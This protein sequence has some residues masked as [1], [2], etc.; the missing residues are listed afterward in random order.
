MPC[1]LRSRQ[2]SDYQQMLGAVLVHPDQREV[3][4]LFPEII[5]NTDGQTKNDCE[6]NAIRRW[7]KKFRQDHPK[8]PVIITEDAL[9]PNAPHIRDLREHNCRFILGVK[10]GDHAFL[11][12]YVDAAHQQGLVTEHTVVDP[13]DPKITHRFRFLDQVPLNQSNLDV[14]VTFV[15]YWQEGPKGTK[16]FAWVTDLK[17][18]TKNVYKIMRGGRARHRTY[19]HR[20]DPPSG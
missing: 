10:S 3:I 2:C 20:K 15:E 14:L 5:R 4:P 12:D 6:R 16:H 7:L 18:T 9:S 8:L 11:F 19:T 17:V 1:A 13:K